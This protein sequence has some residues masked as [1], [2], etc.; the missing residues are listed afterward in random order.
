MNK[1][2]YFRV[3]ETYTNDQI[4]FTLDL[5]NLGGIRPAL[6]SNRNPRHVAVITAAEESERLRAENPYRDR[7]EGDVLIYTAQG[8]EGD[9]SLTGRNKR[10]VEQYS[11]PT[12]FFGF[13]NIGRQIYRFLGLLELLR[14]YQENQADKKGTLRRVWLFEFRIHSKPELVPVK[15]AASIMAALLAESRRSSPAEPSEREVAS[16]PIGNEARNKGTSLAELESVRAQLFQFKPYDFEHFVR[17]LLELSGFV[18][19]SVTRA[20]ADGGIDVN[21]FVDES[22]DFFAGTHIQA[23]V[24]RWRHSVGSPEINSFRGALSSSAKGIFVTT[25]H[26][27]R[28]ALAEAR[29]ESKPS[30]ALVDGERLAAIVIRSGI[31]PNTA[32]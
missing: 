14:H 17:T 12:P 6:D 18:R 2:E 1:L 27:T 32:N 23:Q 31:S 10:L 22:N 19:V 11:I 15:G 24:K 13:A 20:S 30:I 4:R 8:R 16:L 5:E 28:A 25:S 7:I 3:G 26:F 29:H 21:A 9:Q